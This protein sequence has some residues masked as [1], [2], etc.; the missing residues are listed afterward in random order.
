MRA[1][2][3]LNPRRRACV[4]KAIDKTTQELLNRAR[5]KS[6][7][8][9]GRRTVGV[10]ADKSTTYYRT[11]PRGLVGCAAHEMPPEIISQWKL[12]TN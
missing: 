3:K 7:K 5:N 9:S 4:L 1:F 2:E 10:F 6:H 12:T 8:L 11:V